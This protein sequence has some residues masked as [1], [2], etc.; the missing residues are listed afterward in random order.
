MTLIVRYDQ[1][2]GPCRMLT[3]AGGRVPAPD[4]VAVGCGHA[5]CAASARGMHTQGRAAF[6]FLNTRGLLPPWWA[7]RSWERLSWQDQQVFIEMVNKAEEAFWAAWG[8]DA[9]RE[10]HPGR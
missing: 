6:T 9:G 10:G 3:P 1:R 7:R 5:S 8:S 4:T 2:A